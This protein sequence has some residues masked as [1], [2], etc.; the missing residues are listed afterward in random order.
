[1]AV[2]KHSIQRLVNSTSIVRLSEA[3]LMPE[4]H[5]APPMRTTDLT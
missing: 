3:I 2:H 4:Q 5:N 1:L